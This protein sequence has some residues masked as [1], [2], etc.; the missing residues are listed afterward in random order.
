MT[1]IASTLRQTVTQTWVI[2]LRD[3]K[4]WQREPWGPIF[5]ILFA[6]MMLLI[7]GYLFGGAIEMPGGGS[8]LPYLLPGVL[9]LTMM[10]GIDGTM[11]V[12]TEDTKRGVT[13]RF[14]SLPMSG[15]AV[16]LGRAIADLGNSAV[17]LGVLMLG[18]L[19]I[20]WRIEGSFLEA[21]A[22]VGLLLW[23]RLAMLWLGIFL[24]LTLRMEGALT[25][26]QVLVWP[27]GFCSSLF[28]S[29]ETMPG[30]LGFLASWNPVSATATACRDLFGNP[31]GITSGVL[32]DHATLLA[33]AWPAVLLAVFVPLS[34]RAFRR[35]G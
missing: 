25:M 19:L 22:A 15:L 4:H 5:G 27:L 34:V 18:G 10:F 3:L 32:A 31:T 9:A 1:A 7:F 2:T 29:P 35:L 20:G 11:A 12:V 23:L 30:W 21:V 24:G 8:Y 28:V 6:I 33:L 16:P 14:R 17:Q 26:V 13:N